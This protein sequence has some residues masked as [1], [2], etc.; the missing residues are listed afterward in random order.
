MHVQK[1]A[2][3]T[4]ASGVSSAFGAHSP[5]LSSS[6]GRRPAAR[7]S[8]EGRPSGKGTA[9]AAIHN[10]SLVFTNNNIAAALARNHVALLVGILLARDVTR[11]V[12]ATIQAI[13]KILS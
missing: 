4:A 8:S 10:I 6:E 5:V 9:R 2:N 11:V 1:T 13:M 3:E 12:I 7:L